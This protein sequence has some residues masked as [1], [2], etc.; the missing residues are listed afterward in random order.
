MQLQLNVNDARANI[1]LSYL[2]ALKSS[3]YK[4]GIKTNN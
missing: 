3:M 4:S 1:L 2:E